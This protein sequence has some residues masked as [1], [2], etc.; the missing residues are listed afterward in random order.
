MEKNKMKKIKKT[1]RYFIDIYWN[2]VKNDPLFKGDT[3]KTFAKEYMAELNYI[4][5]QRKKL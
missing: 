5:K 2:E 1:D 3:K 4:R